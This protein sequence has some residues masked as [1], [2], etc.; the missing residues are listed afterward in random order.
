MYTSIALG[1]DGLGL[2]SYYDDANGD[3]KVVH[4]AE[5]RLHRG[6]AHHA[7]QR[8]GCQLVYL[9]QRSAPD[10]LR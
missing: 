8:R 2:I 10:G 9:D 4:C 3:L 1:A 7:G 6:N 5:R